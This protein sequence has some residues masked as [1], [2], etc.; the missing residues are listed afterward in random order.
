MFMPLS[1]SLKIKQNLLGE[2]MMM[3][4]GKTPTQKLLLK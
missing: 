2:I 3:D 1:P 4:G